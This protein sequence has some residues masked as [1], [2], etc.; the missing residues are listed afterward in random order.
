MASMQ[1]SAPGRRRAQG[2]KDARMVD[3]GTTFVIPFDRQLL[4]PGHGDRP[5][6]AARQIA[7]TAPAPIATESLAH[8]GLQPFC[9]SRKLEL[10]PVGWCWLKT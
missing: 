4:P 6:G 2:A 10:Y 9:P 8:V 7:Q 5:K 3:F 1:P